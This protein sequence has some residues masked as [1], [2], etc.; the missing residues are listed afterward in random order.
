MIIAIHAGIFPN[1][2]YPWLRIAVPLFF[3]ISSYF[4]FLNIRPHPNNGGEIAK[5]FIK[6]NF[7]LYLF[8]FLA[9]LPFTVCNR[10]AWW[11]GDVVL[12]VFTC[13]KQL[14]FSSTFTASWYIV[15]SMWAC[16]IL[17]KVKL[18]KKIAIPCLL[19][20]YLLCCISS[21]YWN[22][23]PDGFVKTSLNVYAFCLTDP[24]FSFPIALVWMYIGKL[25]AE[26][27]L[28]KLKRE[29]SY[30]IAIC[31]VAIFA[32]ALYSEWKFVCLYNEVVSM[33][34]MFFLLPL[35]ICIF[36]LLRNIE[37]YKRS[38]LVRYLNM[39]SIISYPLHPSVLSFVA[40]IN[41]IFNLSISNLFG[42]VLTVLI[43]HVATIAI[44]KLEKISVLSFLKYSH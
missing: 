25:F 19:V 1:Y 5:N 37:I 2:L 20:V 7:R 36:A 32:I 10:R 24:V 4:L 35:C 3:I 22:V 43:C 21:S 39:E 42:F 40:F 6:R 23:V 26:E 12:F 44:L 27:D 30:V 11:T 18:S 15:A 33:D 9:S 13:L 16:F 8:W 28:L 29:K 17:C 41:K 31:S 14:V 38:K 34:V